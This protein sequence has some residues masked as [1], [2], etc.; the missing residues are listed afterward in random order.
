M[1]KSGPV[2]FGEMH[3]EL[4]EGLALDRA[5]MISDEIET[6][7]KNRFR[8]IESMVIH[9]EPTQKEKIKISI[10]VLEDKR[11]KSIITLHFGKAPLFAFIETEKGQIKRIYA[12]VNEAAKLTKKKGITA[13]HFLVD[14]KVDILLTGGLGEGPFHVLGDN[15]VRIY[16]LPR[17]VKIEEAVRLL[18]QNKLKRMTSPIEKHEKRGGK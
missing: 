4:Q 8:D 13:A 10:P 12:K 2:S 15:L 11:L 18:N 17:P 7:I 14:Q 5:H 3:I 16:Y 1:R 6:K 9:M